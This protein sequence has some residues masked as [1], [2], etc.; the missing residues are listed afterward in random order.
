MPLVSQ[1]A[2][3][4]LRINGLSD[5]VATAF[6]SPARTG[7]VIW[8]AGPVLLLPTATNNALGGE[9]VGIGR[10]VVALVQPGQW[11]SGILWNQIWSADGAVDR[12][13]IDRGFF[14]PFANYNLGEGLA[15]G[16]SI[17]ATANWDDE[18]V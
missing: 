12:P 13:D 5:T 18:E 16:A 6:L 14:Q 4:G 3:D 2:D 1:P 11:T 17:D 10:S 8:G 7:R 9:H 15:A